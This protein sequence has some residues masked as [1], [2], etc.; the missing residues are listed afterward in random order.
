MLACAI[1]R[2]KKKTDTYLYLLESLEFTDLP[3][4]LR[5]AFGEPVFV[6]RLVLTAERKLAHADVGQVSR[7]LREH[8]YFLQLPPGL[9]I[10]EEITRRFS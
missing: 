8:G 3:E 5:Q 4:P 10:E 1:F 7:A 6:M 9:P 2:S